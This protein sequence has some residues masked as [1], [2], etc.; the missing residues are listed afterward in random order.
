MSRPRT[1]FSEKSWRDDEFATRE[2]LGW[3]FTSGL[4]IVIMA[5]LA[6][7]V[8]PALTACNRAR[9][10]VTV[11]A[12]QD[13]VYAEP[14]LKEFERQTGIRVRAVYDS[15]AVK[16]VAIAQRLLN[17]RSNPKC[18]V[19]WGNEELRTRQLAG[20]GVFRETNG[21]AAFGYRSRRIAMAGATTNLPTPVS[22]QDLTNASYRGRLALAYPLFG[23]T[24]THFHALRQHWGESNWLVWCRALAANRPFIVEGNSVAVQFVTRAEAALALTD[25]DDISAAARE[26]AQL[27]AL[28]LSSD[29]LLI[30]NTVAVIR[31]SPHPEAA[32]RLFEH[33]QSPAV[34]EKLVAA[35]A[36]EG[37]TAGSIAVSTLQPDWDAL[38]RD[39]D[40]T[41][42]L[43]RQVFRR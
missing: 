10:T 40:A 1:S 37:A 30:P 13:Q 20:K 39:L 38:L 16:T 35:N 17:E 33:L 2:V 15:E 4:P 34:A 25:S 41:T 21:W 31:N 36:L 8:L 6:G 27:R 29:S 9:S 11:Y 24:A 19:F 3:M 22:F 5:L 12:A 26:G 23:T 42:D 43:L 7:Y 18:D 32:Q 28:P 14:I